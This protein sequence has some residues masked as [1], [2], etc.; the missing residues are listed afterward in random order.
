[1][2]VLI[3]NSTLHIGGAER[4]AACLS[5]HLDR[6]GFEVTACYLKQNG[7]VGEGMLA[8]GVDLVPVPGHAGG[9]PDWLTSLKLLRLIRRRNIQLVHTH[10]VHGL[11]DAS[12]CRSLLPGLRHV[13]TF[14]FGNYPHREPQRARLERLLWRIPDALIAVGHEQSAAL[15]KLYR[16]P[17]SRV[18]V[19]WN[20][21]DEPQACIAQDYAQLIRSHP[22][23]VIVSISTLIEQKGL[24]HLLEAAAILRRRGRE[25]LLLIGG[26]GC[27]RSA[28]ESQ[29]KILHLEDRVRFLGWVPQA[30]ARLLPAADIFVQSSLWE[31]MS[32]VV[33]EAMAARKA[34]VV[35]SVGE[36]PHVVV[37]GDTGLMVAPGDA[38]ALACAL[39][40]VIDEQPLR[41]RLGRQARARYERLFTVRHMVAA[42]ES[43]YKELLGETTTVHRAA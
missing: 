10:D 21:V 23:P 25:F 32:I 43:L 35:T 41:E 40:K 18:R 13:H 12:L 5:E 38:A 28:L 33:L 9:R 26:E 3:V 29:A 20:G 14:H 22:G 37:D 39:D 6:R 7:I 17:E 31:A 30:S 15:R 34:M 1:M 2:R 16:I 8:A 36:N 4:V 27:L 11:V 19:L 24:A 42:H